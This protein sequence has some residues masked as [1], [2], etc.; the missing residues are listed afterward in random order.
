MNINRF[1]VQVFCSFLLIMTASSAFA[2]ATRTWVSGVGDDA[3]PCSRTAPC[4]TFQGA[5]SKTAPAGTIDVLDPGGFGAVTITKSITLENIGFIAGVLVSGTNGI[6]VNAGVNDVVVLR[7]LTIDG[8]NTGLSGV[9]FLN[10]AKL[11]VERCTIQNFT[12]NGIDFNPAGTA[13]L[14]VSDS[15]INN[16]SLNFVTGA[17]ILLEGGNPLANIERTRLVH[18]G[19]A[20]MV[21]VGEAVLHASTVSQNAMGVIVGTASG[22]GARGSMRVAVDDSV[23]SNNVNGG[24]VATSGAIILSRSTVAYNGTGVSGTVQSTGDNRIFGNTTD[25]TVGSSIPLH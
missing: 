18:N 19:N 17:G 25:G 22:G 10:G 2:Q 11:V 1:F 13:Q 6:I 16:N 3:N 7:G 21:E 4:K 20:V 24:A 15:T 23:I 5:I 8:I 9:R 14:V 12:Q